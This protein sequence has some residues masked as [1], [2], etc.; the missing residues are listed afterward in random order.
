MDLFLV[1]SGSLESSVR[2]NNLEN[3]VLLQSLNERKNVRAYALDGHCEL[4][5]NCVGNLGLVEA[6]LQQFEDV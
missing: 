3:V 5:A 4:S 1:G 2:L 6:L